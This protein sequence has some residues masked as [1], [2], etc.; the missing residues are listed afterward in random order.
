MFR[1]STTT[2][3]AHKG[4]YYKF[5]KRQEAE[6]KNKKQARRA[7]VANPGCG[8]ARGCK[9]NAPNGRKTDKPPTL[10]KPHFEYKTEKAKLIYTKFRTALVVK[11]GKKMVKIF[12]KVVK[13]A[14]GDFDYL[15]KK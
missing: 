15:E 11:N 3:N 9:G 1:W 6:E 5:L 2:P 8:R 12:K 4:R 7:G 14:I 10:K 13:G